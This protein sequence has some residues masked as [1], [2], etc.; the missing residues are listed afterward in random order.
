MLVLFRK[1]MQSLVVQTR[2][3]PVVFRILGVR[4][5]KVRLGLDYPAACKVETEEKPA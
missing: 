4:G 3:G 5:G 2:D 1:R